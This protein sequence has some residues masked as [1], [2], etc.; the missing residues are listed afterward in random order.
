MRH[1]AVALSS[2]AAAGVAAAPL[3]IDLIST[4]ANLTCGDWAGPTATCA[5]VGSSGSAAA[6]YPTCADAVR[7]P[8]AF[9]EA[10]FEINYLKVY[11]V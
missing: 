6:D 3:A 10:Y 4:L 5:N 11:S 1:G 9:V 7:D 2:L 8:A